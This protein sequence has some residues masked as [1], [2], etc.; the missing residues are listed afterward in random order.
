M[1][2]ELIFADER[3]HVAGA[4]RASFGGCR[5]LSAAALKPSELPRVEGLDALFLSLPYAERWGPRPVLYKAQVLRTRPE[6]EGMPPYVIT[7]VAMHEDDPRDARFE[8]RLITAAVL[9]AVELHNLSQARPVARVGLWTE[10]LG[11]DRLEP[12]AAGDIIRSVY[13]GRDAAPA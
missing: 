4:L 11:M 12:Q 5:G 7:G 6:D 10:M 13:E 8:L 3:E 9:D 1:R 2:P